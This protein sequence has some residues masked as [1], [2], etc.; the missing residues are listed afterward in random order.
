[1]QLSVVIP[2]YNE[3]DNVGPLL[4]ELLPVL[5]RITPSFEVLF[6]D[7]GSR[8]ETAARIRAHCTLEP[9]VKLLRLSR[10]FGKEAALSAGIDHAQGEAVVLMDADRQHPPAVLPELVAA[11]QAGADMVIASRQNRNTDSVLRRW[12]TRAFYRLFNVLSEVEL[13]PQAGD[14]RLLDRRAVVA[15]Q[16]M[17]ERGR[18]MKGLYA[19]VGLSS[20]EVPYVNEFR[21]SGESRFGW[22]RLFRFALEGLTAFTS[23][24]LRAW[25]YVG[26]AL[27]VPAGLYAVY[28]V[29]RTLIQGVDV[30]GYASLA[31][32]ILFFSGVQLIGLG[33][34]GE[35]LGRVYAEAKQR[36]LYVVSEVVG[37]VPQAATPFTH[38]GVVLPARRPRGADERVPG[39]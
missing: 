13:S 21:A 29:F 16:A 24:P 33:V 36:P 22:R 1:M 18:F 35:Y 25:A 28:L 9:R 15:L 12:L 32:M 5:E 26:F 3:A 38:G 27:A 39:P 11:W 2:C 34:L 10:N 37:A 6:V 14:F 19:L 7:D 8:D 23:A 30:P 31:T 17:P 20:A 4:A